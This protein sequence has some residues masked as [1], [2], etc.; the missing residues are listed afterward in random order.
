MNSGSTTFSR[1]RTPRS[2]AGFRPIGLPTARVT[3][4]RSLG[5]FL[6]RLG[7]DGHHSDLGDR[8]TGVDTDVLITRFASEVRQASF[9]VAQC[10]VLAE[11]GYHCGVIPV[12]SGMVTKLAPALGI[13]LPRG[14]VAHE[15]LRGLLQQCVAERPEEYR[16]LAARHAVTIPDNATPTWWTHLTLI[17]FKRLFL[18]RPGPRLCT[19]SPVCDEVIDCPHAQAR[20]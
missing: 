13:R 12:D 2:N 19:L 9:K 8:I 11:R 15:H 4:L 20:D 18:N 16:Q 14:A 10:A 7:H 17:Y 1:H 3:Y 5:E 6:D